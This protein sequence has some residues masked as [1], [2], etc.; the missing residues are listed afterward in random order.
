MGA[1]INALIA[2]GA[3]C[4]VPLNFA[5]N[6]TQSTA[7]AATHAVSTMV[8]VVDGVWIMTCDAIEIAPL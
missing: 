7:R 4:W 8:T 5:I 6:K 2:V 3:S 1:D